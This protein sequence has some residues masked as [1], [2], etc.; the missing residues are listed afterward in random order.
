MLHAAVHAPVILLRLGKLSC[1]QKHSQMLAG[2]AV[3]EPAGRKPGAQQAQPFRFAV[4]VDGP[5]NKLLFPQTGLLQDRFQQRDVIWI[6]IMRGGKHRSFLLRQTVFPV[7]S[8]QNDRQG[9]DRLGAASVIAHP[10]RIAAGGGNAGAV[11]DRDHAA[12]NTFEQLAAVFLKQDLCFHFDSS[13][14][15][16]IHR[17]VS[18]CRSR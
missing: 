12:V 1:Q 17:P 14:L 10:I 18:L 3:I 4:G 11:H 13:T 5:H 15:T 6:A 16:G 2:A 8:P 7:E 9:L